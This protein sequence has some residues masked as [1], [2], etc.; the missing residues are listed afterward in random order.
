MMKIRRTVIALGLALTLAV[1]PLGAQT[2]TAQLQQF[3]NQLRTGSLAFATLHLT[4]SAYANWGTTLGTDGY[5]LRDNAGTL[6]FKNSGGSWAALIAGITGGT[7]TAQFVRA[8]ST[9]GA[10]TCASVVLTADV[11]GILPGANGGTA[12]GFFAVS[13]PSASLKTFAFPNA[14]DTVATYGVA[15]TFT[16]AQTTTINGITTT[17]TD[18]D[19]QQN[20]T[21]AVIGTTIQY[22]PRTKWCG[23]A[24][25]SVSTLSET[26]CYIVETQPVTTAGTTTS[27]WVLSRNINGGAFG[28]ML[29]INSNGN[30][31]ITGSAVIGNTQNYSLS[32]RSRMSST[33]SG[34]MQFHNSGQT[35]VALE[36]NMGTAVPTVANC[37]V[38]TTGT[39]SVHSTNISGEIN[40]GTG[41]TS[42]DVVFGAPNWS[43]APFCTITDETSVLAPKISARS[44]TGFTVTGLT[45]G[46]KF[47]YI[48]LGGGI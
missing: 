26:D 27:N 23:T 15:N 16:A 22:S 31:T 30:A 17:S 44:A 24:Y 11:T 29:V 4:A 35:L 36:L 25:N 12:N 41:S 20:T 6:Q 37:S 7:C 3:W 38:G 47:A 9:A 5:G 13:G 28:Q 43:F 10:V 46:D 42:C 33:A 48:C 40:P 8:I 1:A 39:V 21:A 2:F 19:I 14:S 34:L 32:G 45:A 18:G